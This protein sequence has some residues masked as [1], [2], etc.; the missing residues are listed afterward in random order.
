MNQLSM[1]ELSGFGGLL[2]LAL[3][4]WAI[5]SVFNSTVSTGKK[6]IWTLLILFLPILG[7]IVWLI[8]GP[9]AAQRRI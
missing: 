5:I 1:F 7:F 4:L 9:R 3:D 6:V 2:I 8:M